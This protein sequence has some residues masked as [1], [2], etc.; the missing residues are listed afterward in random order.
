MSTTFPSFEVA[1]SSSKTEK[2]TRTVPHTDRLCRDLLIIAQS[3]QKDEPVFTI[4]YR[5]FEE[6]TA[7]KSSRL[8]S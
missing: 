4:Q 5:T 3:K 8:Q 1:P 2:R 6:P 7:P